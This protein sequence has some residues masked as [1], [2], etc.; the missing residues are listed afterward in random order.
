[1]SHALLFY[2]VH[3]GKKEAKKP[4]HNKDRKTDFWVHF[5]NLTQSSALAETLAVSSASVIII[6]HSLHYKL[7]GFTGAL[8]V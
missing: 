5:S 2:F 6:Y 7:S 3:V 8:R 1:M 4:K